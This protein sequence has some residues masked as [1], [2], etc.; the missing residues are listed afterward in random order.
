MYLKKLEAIQ[1]QPRYWKKTWDRDQKNSDIS[2][3]ETMASI[4][5]NLKCYMEIDLE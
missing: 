5:K 2:L 3:G 4:F 1:K